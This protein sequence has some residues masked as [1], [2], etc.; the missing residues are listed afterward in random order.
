MNAEPIKK[1]L[2]DKLKAAG[3]TSVKLAFSGGSDEGYLDVFLYPSFDYH[4]EAVRNLVEEVEK[5]A[6]DIYSYSGAGDGS[7]YGDNITYDLVNNTVETEEWFTE[8]SYGDSESGELVVD[9]EE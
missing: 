4:D 8:R 5:W 7:D 9:S 3:V 1:S 2:Y 6:W